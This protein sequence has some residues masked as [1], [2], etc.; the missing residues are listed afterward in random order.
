MVDYAPEM[1]EQGCLFVNFEARSAFA[2]K[3]A[4]R[5]RGDTIS[6]TTPGGTAFVASVRGMK[7]MVFAGRSLKPGSVS[8]PPD[9]EC[10]IGPVE[11]TAKGKLVID[12]S[13]PLPGLGVIREPV[14]VQVEHGLIQ[15]ICGGEEAD[16]LR[17]KL[18][19]YAD[20]RVYVIAEIGIGMNDMAALSGR[21]LEDEGA[22]GTM[23]IG[24]GNNLS[25]GGSCS[26]GVH[27]DMIMRSP[28]CKVDGA[29]VMKDGV[30]AE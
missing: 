21:M 19:S 8:S 15:S 25:Y 3:T 22:Y 11:G 13:I 16:I 2:E 28:T 23:H 18:A 6:V 14:H 10:A 9:I 5:L 29:I 1:L 12:G 4:Q 30:V 7:P 27:I 24:I 26:T 20:G 17:K